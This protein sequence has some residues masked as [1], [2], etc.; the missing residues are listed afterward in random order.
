MAGRFGR[1]VWFRGPR[2]F[3]RGPGGEHNQLLLAAVL[4][5]SLALFLIHQ[6]DAA[7]RPQLVSLAETQ[8]RNQVTRIADQ[9]VE[10][11]L[12]DQAVSYGDMVTLQTNQTGEITTLTTDTVRLNRLRG[13]IMDDVVSRVQDLDERDLGVP[14]GALTG[15]D[16]LSAMGPKLPVQV[17]SMASAEAEYRNDFTG[18]GINQTIHR[19]MLDVTV[20]AKLLLPGGIVETRVTTPVC[21]AETVIVGQVPDA[22]MNWNQ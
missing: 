17:L 10:R 12:N 15:L 20:T 7:L 19:V 5:V 14:L 11:A 2:R 18:A 4:G 1:G 8:V 6:F 22:Y 13:E 16:L 3:G 21:V 9:A